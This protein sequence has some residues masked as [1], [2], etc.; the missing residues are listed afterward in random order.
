MPAIPKRIINMKHYYVNKNPQIR[1]EH[2]VHPS[3]CIYLPT[4]ENRQYLGYFN[5]CAEAVKE[6]RKFYAN[7]DGCFYCC[8]QCHTK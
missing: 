7:V 6:A 1:G 4:L 5:N 2:E 8:P 3:D